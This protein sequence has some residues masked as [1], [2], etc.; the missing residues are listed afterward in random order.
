M[1]LSEQDC[2][3]N[4][5]ASKG[6]NNVAFVAAGLTA[7]LKKPLTFPCDG[8]VFCRMSFVRLAGIR[9]ALFNVRFRGIL[10]QMSFLHW[11]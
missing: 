8:L 7:I 3:P 4:V 6:T 9:F 5:L 2:H 1:I 11:W 10:L